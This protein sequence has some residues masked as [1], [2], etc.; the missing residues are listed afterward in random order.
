MLNRVAEK[1]CTQMYKMPTIQLKVFRHNFTATLCT[2][3]HCYLRTMMVIWVEDP[4]IYTYINIYPHTRN[5]HVQI[6]RKAN[7]AHLQTPPRRH[8]LDGDGN[9]A[10][11][12]L[13]LMF[14]APT[15]GRRRAS[16]RVH[17][18]RSLAR[19]PRRLFPSTGGARAAQSG[20]R[21]PPPPNRRTYTHTLSQWAR[22]YTR[23]T[24]RTHI[25]NT[26][27]A[28]HV[29][30]QCG[31][32]TK[33]SSGPPPGPLRRTLRMWVC[34]CVLEC[35]IGNKFA[36]HAHSDSGAVEPHVCAS[37]P[38]SPLSLYI[39]FCKC[40]S[41]S[42]RLATDKR[43]T[44]TSST[45]LA[46]ARPWKMFGGIRGTRVCEHTHTQMH[47]QLPH[48][49]PGRKRA[50]TFEYTYDTVHHRHTSR[51]VLTLLLCP[52]FRAYQRHPLSTQPR[53][54]RPL[55]STTCD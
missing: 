31:K 4:Q 25:A 5:T 27:R 49:R 26:R 15:P 33:L 43:N 53:T 51:S 19:E 2:I 30:Y 21:S 10:Q 17:D 16:S 12:V 6:A 39:S 8:Q 36:V 1:C 44:R 48:A 50:H 18:E 45:R 28:V 9:G 52:V 40:R 3:S 46:P 41:R 54:A 38:S 20:G 47:R 7:E 29:L 34:V 14:I 11:F 35:V 13:T 24:C 37:T 42:G 22:V 32:V 23:P 55:L